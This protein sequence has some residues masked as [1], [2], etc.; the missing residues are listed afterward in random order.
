MVKKI[1]LGDAGIGLLL[2]GIFAVHILCHSRKEK[3]GP[4]PSHE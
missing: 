3:P 1:V 2:V 4:V